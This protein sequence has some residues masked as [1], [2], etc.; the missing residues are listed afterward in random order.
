MIA[1]VPNITRIFMIFDPTTFPIAISEFPL[2]AAMIDVTSSGILVPIA[3]TVRPMIDC[4][5]Q[6]FFA[7]PTAPST[8]IFHPVKRTRIHQATQRRAFHVE[9][10]FST[11]SLSSGMKLLCRTE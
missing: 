7:I 3:T 10:I 11:F 5:S 4:E 6:K 9:I 1:E 8:N 2:L